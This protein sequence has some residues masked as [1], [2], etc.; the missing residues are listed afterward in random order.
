MDVFALEVLLRFSR[1]PAVPNWIW[2]LSFADYILLQ[3]P[4]FSFGSVYVAVVHI[5][6]SFAA[7]P[8]R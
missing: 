7:L 5:I 8:A 3:S 6:K 2:A 4:A 1:S